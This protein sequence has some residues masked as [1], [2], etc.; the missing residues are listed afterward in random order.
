MTTID[1]AGNVHAVQEVIAA[2]CRRAGRAPADVLSSSFGQ[3]D[4]TWHRAAPDSVADHLLQR[5]CSLAGAA[6]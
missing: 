3:G 4:V 6:N 1:V 2:A 5:V